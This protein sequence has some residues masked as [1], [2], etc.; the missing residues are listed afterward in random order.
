MKTESGSVQGQRKA[1]GL[2]ALLLYRLAQGPVDIE[3]FAGIL[4]QIYNDKIKNV[5][6]DSSVLAEFPVHVDLA[7]LMKKKRFKRKSDDLRHAYQQYAKETNE[8]PDDPPLT[9][10]EVVNGWADLTGQDRAEFVSKVGS[11]IS[12]LIIEPNNVNSRTK[13][14]LE[15]DQT[16]AAFKFTED[17]FLVLV[18]ETPPDKQDALVEQIKDSILNEDSEPDIEL[19]NEVLGLGSRLMVSDSI[20]TMENAFSVNPAAKELFSQPLYGALIDMESK[21]FG[22]ESGV[23]EDNMAKLRAEL[24]EKNLRLNNRALTH[25]LK[26]LGRRGIC[27]NIDSA[28]EGRL[29]DELACIAEAQSAIEENKTQ[30]TWINETSSPE[31]E[32]AAEKRVQEWLFRREGK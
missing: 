26:A 9:I 25:S 17:L 24:K 3:Y 6:L 13:L 19:T 31:A 4:L 16:E 7:K 27:L 29:M 2:I 11:K 12:T 8:S 21:K 1:Q 23:P 15:N 28:L 22:W 18:E 32:A 30:T 5:H 20:A 14:D 10:G